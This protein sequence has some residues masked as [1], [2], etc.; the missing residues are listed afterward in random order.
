MSSVQEG[1][2]TEKPN[3]Q[4]F[5]TQA[6]IFDMAIEQRFS[7]KYQVNC[8]SGCWDWTASKNCGYGQ[9]NIGGKPIFAHR[10]SH[11]LHKGP[12]PKNL[13]VDHICRNRGCVNPLHLRLLTRG[14]NVMCGDTIPAR[15]KQAKLCP[16]GHEYVG[17]NIYWHRGHRHCRECRKI[18]DRNRRIREHAAIYETSP[19]F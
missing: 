18:H 7:A 1:S 14:E 15:K 13:V 19:D 8:V 12:I 5:T 9:M 17:K 11:I 3:T 10:I 6:R 2:F 4:L 16:N